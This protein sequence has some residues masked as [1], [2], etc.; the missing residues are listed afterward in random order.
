MSKVNLEWSFWGYPKYYVYDLANSFGPRLM[1]FLGEDM[2]KL[3]L[4]SEILTNHSSKEL[5]RVSDETYK[6]HPAAKALEG[7]LEKVIKGKKLRQDKNDRIGNVFGDKQTIARSKMR[8]PRLIAKVKA[9]WDYCRNDIMHYGG[10]ELS[11]LTLKKTH[12]EIKEII[13]AVYTDLYGKSDPSDEVKKIYQKE[14][15]KHFNQ[16]MRKLKKLGS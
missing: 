3:L 16:S 7:F 11:F 2:C 5:N 8:D 14:V 15:S 10:Q 9:T 12:D 4:D 6:L 1:D 13:F